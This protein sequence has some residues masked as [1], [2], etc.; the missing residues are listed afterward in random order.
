MM[1][2]NKTPPHNKNLWT[3]MQKSLL[4]VKLRLKK[5]LKW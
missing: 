4:H 5:N 3:F 2:Q 1:Q